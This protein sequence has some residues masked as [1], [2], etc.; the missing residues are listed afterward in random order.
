MKLNEVLSRI[1]LW[2]E[3]GASVYLKS[4]PGLGK[5]TTIMQAPKILSEAT[6]KNI[7]CVVIQGPLL[8]PGDA[9]GYLMPRHCEDGTIESAYSQP[10][11]F[12]TYEN[13]HL[14]EFDG[15]IIFVDEMDKADTDVKK[16]LGECALSGRLGP[17][18]LNGGWVLWG[19]GNRSEDRSGSTKEL[20]HLINRRMEVDVQP[21]LESLLD[22]MATNNVSPLTQAFAKQYP[23]IVLTGKVPE[24]QGPWC[25]PR[26]LVAA[27]RHLALAAK[28]NAGKLPTDQIVDEEIRGMIGAAA[29]AQYFSHVKLQLELPSYESI[30]AAPDKAPT[31]AKPDAMMLICY[32]MAHRVSKDD[33]TQAVTYINRL[34]KE[35][36]VTFAKAA[37]KR[38]NTLV[39]DRAMQKWALDN[40]SL[41]SVIN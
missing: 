14:S 26:S 30:I 32:N 12:R 33:A 15:G 36:G 35:F 24:K 29:T 10:Y 19:A 21:D 23:E 8:T 34:P 17:H 39:L 5:T 9:I 27:D 7:G 20:D 25:T 13:K 16:V 4:P 1:P 2:Y 40:S 22:W 38:D 28:H 11:W 6:G 31:P 41:M 37:I 18:R 3:S